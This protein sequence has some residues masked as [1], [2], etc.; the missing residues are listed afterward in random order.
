MVIDDGVKSRG[1]RKNIF[2][3]NFKKI[4]IASG[5]HKGYTHCTV[6]EFFGETDKQQLNFN[7]YEIDKEEWPENATQLQKH[8]ES[9]TVND[10]KT[11]TLTYTFTLTNGEKIV[12]KKEFTE[13]I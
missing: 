9:K 2:G 5:P 13:K 1:H 6:M 11:I 7:K 3:S 12:K 8:I 10:V 4:G